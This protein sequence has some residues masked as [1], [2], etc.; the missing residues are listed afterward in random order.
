MGIT[1]NVAHGVW[2][3]F[4]GLEVSLKLGNLGFGLWASGH[5]GF[6]FPKAKHALPLNCDARITPQFGKTSTE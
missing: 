6:G 4:L 1:T 2:A 5:R 3:G